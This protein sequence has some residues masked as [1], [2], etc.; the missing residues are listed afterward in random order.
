MGSPAAVDI[1]IELAFG[2][3]PLDDLT[4]A[5][6]TDVTDDVSMTTG[7]AVSCSSGRSG[8][9]AGLEP[10]SLEF[11]LEN[12]DGRYSPRNADG[13]YFGELVLGVPV[14]VS[15]TYAATTEVRWLG[16]VSNGWPQQPTESSIP[17]VRV[18]AE[19]CIGFLARGSAPDTALESL[20]RSLDPTW[21]FRVGPTGWHDQ[22]GNRVG[23]HTSELVEVDPLANGDP[24]SWGQEQVA[25]YARV[26]DPTARIPTGGGDEHLLVV[27][28]RA[29]AG[30]GR[31]TDTGTGWQY[32]TWLVSQRARITGAR[33]EATD[34]QL[35]VTHEGI[36][37]QIDDGTY[38]SVWGTLDR[39]SL[40]DGSTHMVAVRVDGTGG[41]IFGNDS[42]TIYVD[43]VQYAGGPTPIGVV[44][45]AEFD[46]QVQTGGVPCTVVEGELVFG[47]GTGAGFSGEPYQ[48]AIDHVML[49]PT[50]GLSSLNDTVADLWSAARTA[51]AGQLLDERASSVLESVGLTERLGAFDSSGIV[52]L[53][54]YRP[55]EVLEL[56]QRIEDTEQGRLWV[57]RLGD[58][59]F[60][61]RS[62]AWDDTTSTTA[63]LVLSD[64]PSL[65]DAG[66]A[67]P[68]LSGS[69][70]IL[71]DQ[72]AVSNVA[73][74][75]SEFGRQQTA[76]DASSVASIG[77]RNAVQLSNLLHPSDRQSLSIAEWLVLVG[78]DPAPTV[79][80]VSFHVDPDAATLAAIAQ[81]L[82]QGALV[83]LV[84][85]APTDTAGD[86]IGA[87][88]ELAG[89]VIGL[90]HSFGFEGWV[91]T[92]HLDPTRA[93][94]GWFTWGSSEWDNADGE[95]WAF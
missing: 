47:A 16:F 6:W 94:R 73:E 52:T 1:T 78:A 38:R 87:D 95:G 57:D 27:M 29:P 49:I 81:T 83:E 21:W 40:M 89:H 68:F 3:G 67:Y 18:T 4:A 66:T 2:S 91:V 50:A 34:F 56:L 72:L 69:L 19:D 88:L 64:K 53:Q 15:T 75:T 13:P 79:R 70:V 24:T 82:D 65:L 30:T 10:G 7:E 58:V 39:G 48:G 8:V 74:V 22:I 93:G 71:D 37:V 5:T 54:S 84:V 41:L 23:S 80:S 17:L 42:T 31:S 11:E 62:W 32:P 20:V 9:R 55:A 77:R 59:R 92:L 43:G 60:S 63:Q 45:P 26:A 25:G 14:R 44:P 36:T 61:A 28:F 86:P 90:E 76:I 85:T 46:N 51:W 33:T 35:I 12:R